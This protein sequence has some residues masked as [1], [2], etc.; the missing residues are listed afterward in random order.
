[1]VPEVFASRL[2]EYAGRHD[3]RSRCAEER[4]AGRSLSEGRMTPGHDVDDYLTAIFAS[5][6]LYLKRALEASE[7]ARLPPIAVSAL[8]GKFCSFSFRCAGHGV[9]LRSARL[10]Y[11]HVRHPARPP[12]LNSASTKARNGSSDPSVRGVL[13]G[14]SK[15]IS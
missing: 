3:V 9:Y 8:Q 6:D 10:A 13:N 11:I 2:Q 15:F 5:G 7:Q 12:L 1:M 14:D 4:E